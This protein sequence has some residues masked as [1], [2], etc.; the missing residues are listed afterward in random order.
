[1]LGASSPHI[2]DNCSKFASLFIEFLSIFTDLVMNVGFSGY[3]SAYFPMR[4]SGG[5]NR[6]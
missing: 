5:L 2:N 4:V 3:A 6:S 1:M